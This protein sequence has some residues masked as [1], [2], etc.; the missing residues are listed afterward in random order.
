[1]VETTFIRPC[2][3]TEDADNHS[4][5]VKS[6]AKDLNSSQTLVFCVA[7]GYFLAQTVFQLV[8]SHMSHGMGRKYAY[9][10]GIA[11]YIIGAVIAATSKCTRQLVAA[12][13]VQGMGAAGMFTMSAIVVV[14][15][16]P[17]RKRA[18]YTAMSQASGALGNICGPL[19][20]A[21][22]FKKFSWVRCSTSQRLWLT[23]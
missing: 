1:M 6:I 15:I 17:P 16:M 9:L 11:L 12:R 20:A 5:T 23:S 8:F 3:L 18:A 21:L 22:L 14:E 13:A 19:F 2:T 7:T 10:C 4:L